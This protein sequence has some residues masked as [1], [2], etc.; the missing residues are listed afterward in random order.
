MSAY[1]LPFFSDYCLPIFCLL[2]VACLCVCNATY[3]TNSAAMD[4]LA[5]EQARGMLPCTCKGIIKA[6]DVESGLVKKQYLHAPVIGSHDNPTSARLAAASADSTCNEACDCCRDG[7]GKG[8]AS[9]DGLQLPDV[10]T[11][12]PLQT[13][14]AM[15]H[16]VAAGMARGKARPAVMVCSCLTWTPSFLFRQPCRVSAASQQQP[17]RQCMCTGARRGSTLRGRFCSACGMSHPGTG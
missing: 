14:H 4:L 9:S 2:P 8:T 15:S 16:A 13:A 10:D 12:L 5:A 7:K 11:F 6:L 1:C 17:S 3:S